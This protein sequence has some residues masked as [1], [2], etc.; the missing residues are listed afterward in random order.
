[1]QE[2][3]LDATGKAESLTRMFAACFTAEPTAA[4]HALKALH[5]AGHL[6]GPVITHNFDVLSARAGLPDVFVRRYD[7]KVPPVPLLDE[8]KALLVV[9]L[10]ADRREVQRRAREKG[11]R[12]FFV[13]PEGLAEN[14]VF[15]EYPIEGA[16]EG[17]VVV[18]GE[19]VPVL[20]RL[21]EILGVTL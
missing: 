6:I 7:Q 18:R 14:G 17:D 21:C 11:I 12:I 3:L 20:V 8:A 4:H 15:K 19:A 5:D 16:R 10:H 13:D 9:G 2:L 1:M